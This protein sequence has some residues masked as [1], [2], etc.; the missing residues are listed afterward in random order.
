MDLGI[1]SKIRRRLYLGLINN[2]IVNYFMIKLGK[3]HQLQININNWR[4]RQHSNGASDNEKVG[5]SQIPHIINL[6]KITEEDLVSVRDTFLGNSGKVLDIGCGNGQFIRFFDSPNYRVYGVDINSDFLDT[7]KKKFPANTYLQGDFLQ[8]SIQEKFNFI[9]CIGVLMYIPPSRIN[10]FFDKIYHSLEK[11]GVFFVQYTH[12]LTWADLLFNNICYLR[13]SP[14]FLES[15]IGDRFE[16]LT[17]EHFFDGRKVV[18]KDD[19]HYYFP[20]GTNSRTDTIENTYKL[21][22]RKK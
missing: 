21:I 14:S 10:I 16:I 7:A 5:Y 12:A 19:K 1:I 20:D 4:N 9:L 17:H 15:V 3:D 8:L 13:Y 22:I 18:D 11:N 2:F 6:L